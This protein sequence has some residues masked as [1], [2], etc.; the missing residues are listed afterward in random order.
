M[1]ILVSAKSV[2]IIIM[3]DSTTDVVVALLRPL[4]PPLVESPMYQLMQAMR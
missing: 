4:A 3:V 1:R 2:T